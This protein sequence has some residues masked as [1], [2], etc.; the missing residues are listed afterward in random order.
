MALETRSECLHG[1]SHASRMA[2]WPPG[3]AEAGG[4]RGQGRQRAH[5]LWPSFVLAAE[6]SL[7]RCDP[8]PRAWRANEFPDAQCPLPKKQ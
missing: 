3:E 4:Q 8:A 5:H 1:A 2:G 7:H 6:Q